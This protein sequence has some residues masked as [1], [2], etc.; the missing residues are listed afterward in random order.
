MKG[1][2]VLALRDQ[3]LPPTINRKLPTLIA[4]WITS[5]ITRASVGRVRAFKIPWLRRYQR[6]ADI[7]ALVSK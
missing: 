6:R 7:Q 5:R 3:I 4:I 2:S 1:I